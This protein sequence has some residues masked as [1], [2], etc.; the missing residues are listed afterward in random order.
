MKAAVF[1]DKNDM[2]IVNRKIRKPNDDEVTIKIEFCGICGTDLH[3]YH[4]QEGAAKTKPPII[5]GHEI[6]GT[7]SAV[8]EDASTLKV[9]DRVCI[10]PNTY[11]GECYYCK[12]AKEHLCNDMVGVG[13]T[14]DGG[15]AEYCTLKSKMVIPIGANLSFEEAAFAEP[16]ACCLHGIDLTDIKV[17]DN[18]LIIGGGN[19]GLIMVQLAKISGASKIILIEP[20][21]NKRKLGLKYGADIAIHPGDIQNNLVNTTI[22]RIDK[23]IECVGKPETI[24]QGIKLASKGATIMMF[25]LTA[26]N[27]KLEIYPF[28]IFKKEL[29]IT[30]SFVNPHTQARTVELLEN[31]RVKVKELIEEILPL[32][33]L[34]EALT[35]DKY[36]RMTKILIKP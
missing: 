6:S 20:D 26:P 33:K 35:E 13:T 24:A 29:K 15:F 30:S 25:G 27:E 5:L 34:V 36:R 7:V 17:G 1:F 32:E 19:I 21:K 4:G 22:S 10:D 14:T 28:E 12:N 31:S 2:K 3:I 9:G 8:G 16:V 23:V 11:C 18:V